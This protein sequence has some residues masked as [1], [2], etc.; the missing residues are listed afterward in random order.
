MTPAPATKW[1]RDRRRTQ[2]QPTNQC[3]SLFDVFNEIKSNFSPSSFPQPQLKLNLPMLPFD[4]GPANQELKDWAQQSDS[5]PL[6][7][8]FPL[9]RSSAEPFCDRR[10]FIHVFIQRSIDQTVKFGGGEQPSG[11]SLF[12]VWQIQGLP[13]R[14]MQ[15]VHAE[16]Y[17]SGE[18]ALIHCHAFL[19]TTGRREQKIRGHKVMTS[20]FVCH[21][22]TFSLW[23]QCLLTQS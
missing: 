19:H 21:C 22:S 6:H 1:P 16:I 13:Q 11:C 14:E 2:E 3:T 17:H 5:V 9:T 8:L 4:F 7:D 12:P 23:V 15:R 18:V 10:R 20:Y